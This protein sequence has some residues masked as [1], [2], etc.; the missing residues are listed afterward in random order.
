MTDLDR[1]ERLLAARPSCVST[2][3]MDEAHTLD[4]LKGAARRTGS[5]VRIWS[6]TQGVHDGMLTPPEA[7]PDT[8]HP[9][10]ALHHLAH[11]PNDCA[12]SERAPAEGALR[13]RSSSWTSPRSASAATSSASTSRSAA[14]PRPP[15]TS[16]PSLAR[17]KLQRRRDRAGGDRHPHRG[18]LPQGDRRTAHLLE[19]LAATR[20]LSVTMSERVVRLRQWAAGQCVRAN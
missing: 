5:A 17:R 9:A 16:R 4:L 6:V 14:T 7:V 3:T 12:S 18:V 20:P 15:S 8:E 2:V 11:Q 13:T 1:L 19:A 10:A